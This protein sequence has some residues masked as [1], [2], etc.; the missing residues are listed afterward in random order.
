[1]LLTVTLRAP[2]VVAFPAASV[3]LAAIDAA[4][5]ATVLESQLIE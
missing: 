3:A 4:P 2:E 1:V 5:F